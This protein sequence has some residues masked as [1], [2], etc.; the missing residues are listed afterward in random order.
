M[1]KLHRREQLK[2]Q[3]EGNDVHYVSPNHLKSVR[4]ES[5]GDNPLRLAEQL[6][7][8]VML[9]VYVCACVCV[10]VLAAVSVCYVVRACGFAVC[11]CVCSVRVSMSVY[12]FCL[13][14]YYLIIIFFYNK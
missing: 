3:R 6:L 14:L 10:R 7:A 9:C 12:L 4:L 2:D 11:V 13:I 5:V 8:C 1:Q